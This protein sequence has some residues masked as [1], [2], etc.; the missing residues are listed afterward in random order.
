MVQNISMRLDHVS[1]V[2]SHDQLAD[3]VQRLGS[4]LGT[5]FVDGGIHPRF[6]TRNFT[7]P[8][9]DGK[10]IEV[11]CPLDHPVT[12]QTPWG[13]AVSKKAQEGGGWLTWVFSTEDI[14]PIEEKFGRKAVD[15]HRTRPD[16]TDLK[17][18]QIGV[19]EITD[20]RELPF[21][22][23]WL[24]EDH[25]S[26]DGVA[27]ASI[28]KIVIADKDELA[29][30]W[31]KEEI[32]NATSGIEIDWIQPESIEDNNGIITLILMRNGEEIILD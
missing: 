32:L 21:F 25:P 11:V 5:T 24:T 14:S 29:D 31:F 13:K 30:S 6:G 19:K 8:L 9:L 10:Y 7:A 18:K 15:G 12:E 17:W 4:R 27:V 1:Y 26:K 20:S 2:T 3:T 28:K 16:G 22:I 23:E